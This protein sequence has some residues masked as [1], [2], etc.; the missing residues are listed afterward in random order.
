MSIESD[1]VKAANDVLQADPNAAASTKGFGKASTDW[2]LKQ[3][4]PTPPPAFTVIQSVQ[5][6]QIIT[7]PITWTATPSQAV[8]KVE[9]FIDGVLKWTENTA[10]YVFNGDGQKFDPATVP[11][12]PHILSVKATNASGMAT[13]SAN[14]TIQGVIPP[15]T[16]WPYAHVVGISDGS[17]PKQQ[18]F[19]EVESI[20]TKVPLRIDYYAQ[21]GYGSSTD[22]ALAAGIPVLCTVFGTLKKSA[23]PDSIGNPAGWPQRATPQW[24][25]AVAGKYKGKI[26]LYEV[27]NEPDLNGWTPTQYAPFFADAAI[28]IKT[29]DPAAKV[30]T[31][32]FFKGVNQNPQQPPQAFAR[33]ICAELIRRNR[34][35]LMDYFAAHPYDPVG[36][37]SPNSLWHMLFPYGDRPAGDTVR[38]ILDANGF[39]NVPIISTEYGDGNSMQNAQAVEVQ[40]KL[41]MVKPGRLGAGFIYKMT[42]QGAFPEDALLNADGTRRQGWTTVQQVLLAK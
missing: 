35:D 41:D 5:T 32:G 21:S 17:D 34:R 27:M 39:Q 29:A 22:L 38:E 25:G 4:P 28:A 42:R 36:W 40:A 33:A 8:A 20:G 3:D 6:G 18:T 9:F 1:K 24:A 13:A 23:T 16:S 12:G 14:V 19:L 37:N 30:S 31:A 2:I 26:P 10:P 11:N 15:P 7:A